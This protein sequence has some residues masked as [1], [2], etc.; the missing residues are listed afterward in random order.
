ML[1][2]TWHLSLLAALGVGL[3][4]AVSPIASQTGRQIPDMQ[5]DASWPQWPEA[6]IQGASAGI[7]IDRQDNVW[8]IHRPANVTEKRACCRPAPAVMEFDSTGKLLQS[9]NG[10]GEGYQWP[11]DGDEHGIFVDYKNNVWVAGRG[12]N[13]TSENQILKF[14]NKGKFLLQIGRRGNGNN[15]ND[16]ANLGQPADMAVYPQTNE[17]F[18]AD[19][20]GNRRVIVF[21]ADT[22]AYKRHWGAYGNKPDDAAPKTPNYQGPGDPQFNQVHHVRISNDGLVYVADR[23]NRRIQIFRVDGTFVKEAFVR[24]DSKENGGTV[25]SFAF[26]ADPQQQFLYV[27]DQVENRIL[28]LDRQ[29]LQELG[30]FGR[31]GRYVG[32]FVS[33]HNIAADSKGNVYVAEDLGGQRVQKF[34]FKGLT[35]Q[36]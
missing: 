18:V 24:R 29:T 36:R 25:S 16:T 21:D 6:W 27:A 2:R 23:L 35:A 28:I 8:I 19:G 17:L 1:V 32:Q 4:I 33:P 9:W 7:A 15:S 13:G 5:V 12:G 22:G 20:Y 31:L 34:V 26:S 3:V 11:L 14:D 30:S 10:P